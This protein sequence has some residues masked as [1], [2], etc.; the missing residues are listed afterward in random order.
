M[1][2]G[3]CVCVCV[4]QL[5]L[6]TNELGAEGARALAPVVA[7][8]GSVTKILVSMNELGD[9]GAT[10]LCNALRESNVTK[11]QELDLCYNSLLDS[12]RL[13]VRRQ[14]QLAG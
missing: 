12:V 6:S 10:I 4:R 7:V 3:A 9:E 14:R 8:M 11:V 2:C 13:R 1:V 5:D